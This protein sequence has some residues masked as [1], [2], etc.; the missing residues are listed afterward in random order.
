MKRAISSE[1]FGVA[2]LW[3]GVSL[4]P[5]GWSLP[6]PWDPLA[7]DYPAMAH[8]DVIVLT[9]GK[10]RTPDIKDRL[11]L[12]HINIKIVGSILEEIKKYSPD[13][14]SVERLFMFKNQNR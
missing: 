12:A 6:S 14:T 11:Q 8:S 13:L 9:A 2:S 10:P 3:F 1:S 4:R 5:D 7:G